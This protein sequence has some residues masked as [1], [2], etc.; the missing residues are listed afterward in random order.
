MYNPQ[1]GRWMAVD[2]WEEDVSPYIY[3]ANDPVNFFDPNGKGRFGKWLKEKADDIGDAAKQVGN[4]VSEKA[5]DAGD[6]AKKF[7]NWV[8]NDAL[9][10]LDPTNEGSFIDR[11]GT[12]YLNTIKWVN[13]YFLGDYTVRRLNGESHETASYNAF[14]F[15][16]VSLAFEDFPIDKKVNDAYEEFD[17]CDKGNLF[18][19][20]SGKFYGLPQPEKIMKL[21][22]PITDFTDWLRYIYHT[23]GKDS[24]G[25]QLYLS[26]MLDPSALPAEGFFEAI[27]G[28]MFGNAVSGSSTFS[29]GTQ[30]EFYIPD[31]DYF[32]TEQISQNA[33][34]GVVFDGRV[35]PDVNFW[36][37]R[38]INQY[39][40][41]ILTL[42]FYDES[43]YNRFTEKISN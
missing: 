22:K 28:S 42:K 7:G 32:V 4:W 40:N 29:D 34:F 31:K 38:L 3:V 6:A 43:L 1:I 13:P 41:T 5:D 12:K 10:E 16:G 19:D 36:R 26:D 11:A 33:L 39:H 27:F 23:E 17:N 37:I 8:K 15:W 20:A 2:P 9:P 30:A 18:A 25:N 21:D 14:A 35:A 24:W